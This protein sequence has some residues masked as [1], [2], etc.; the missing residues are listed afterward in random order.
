LAVL[1]DAE[2]GAP[3]FERVVRST[4]DGKNALRPGSRTLTVR[5]E[6]GVTGYDLA[7]GE[8]R[9]RWEL[10]EG[11]ST[12]GLQDTWGRTTVL[13][14]MRCT[15]DFHQGV[16]A[17]DEVTG[18]ERW[19]HEI[20]AIEAARM[21]LDKIEVEDGFP[22][23]AAVVLRLED[24]R[25]GGMFPESN[26]VVTRVLLDAE[27]GT[28]LAPLDLSSDVRT[29]FGVT[30]LVERVNESHLR[31][32]DPNTGV[33]APFSYECATPRAH[34]T[35]STTFYNA[36][37]DQSGWTL[38]TQPLD[39]SPPTYTPIRPDGWDSSPSGPDVHLVIAPGA[40]VIERDWSSST[41]DPA[42]V[43]LEG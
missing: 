2:T 8:P 13:V 41:S 34:A 42:V 21:G 4:L 11:C 25:A 10:P 20:T 15:D 32:V 36:C 39:G 33:T 43:G 40:V 28:A 23:G 5:D 17:L 30:P 29:E 22:G 14:P 7:D 35:T 27:T 12:Y 1:L 6:N 9:W 31:A 24:H 19:R 16:L 26:A 38:V 3:R 18:Q 37:V